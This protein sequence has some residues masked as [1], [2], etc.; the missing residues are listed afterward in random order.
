MK[1]LV[2]WA[3]A[4]GDLW[5]PLPR[6]RVPVMC[7]FIL[8][9]IVALGV[10]PAMG[11]NSAGQ[12]TE[13]TTAGTSSATQA[14]CDT[15]ND[16]DIPVGST[17]EAKVTS[18]LESAHLKPGKEI[19]AQVV[20]EWESPGCNLPVGSTLY[21]H[22]TAA[23]S[24]KGPDHSEMA[25]VF[26]QGQCDGHSKRPISLTLI[27]VVAPSDQFVGMHS[28]LPSEVA[29]AGRN[30]SNSVGNGGVAQDENLNPGGLPRTVH[31]GIVVRIP[32]LQLEP[33]GGPEC[34]ARMISTKRN[35]RLESGSRLI[36]T[37]RA[38]PE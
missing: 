14:K 2:L 12:S 23:S 24:S 37:M 18:S 7:T 19:T 33:H 8:S 9:G 31:P 1:S 4:N 36:L 38:V 25:I 28:A 29:G 27:G 11:Q 30:I 20:T 3:E 22:V 13:A 32:K 34:S 5:R 6:R 15:S 35:F 10:P 26:D 21:G 16:Q 17:I